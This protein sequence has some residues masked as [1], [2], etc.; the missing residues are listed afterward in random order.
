MFVMWVTV[1]LVQDLDCC[2]NGQDMEFCGV[3]NQFGSL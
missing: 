3:G 2:G 1:N